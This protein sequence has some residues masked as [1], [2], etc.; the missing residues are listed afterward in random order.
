MDHFDEA[1]RTLSGNERKLLEKWLKAY[2][3][4]LPNAKVAFRMKHD[5]ATMAP[6]DRLI[7][8]MCEK[9]ELQPR[10]VCKIFSEKLGTFA[11]T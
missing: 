3:S 4:D 11:E 10:R 7:G 2:F 6:I 1:L 8:A 9:H 5:I